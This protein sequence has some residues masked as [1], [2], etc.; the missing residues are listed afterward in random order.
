MLVSFTGEPKMH[1]D[2]SLWGISMKALQPI[3]TWLVRGTNS[4]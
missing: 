3:L 2:I 4:A 1:I